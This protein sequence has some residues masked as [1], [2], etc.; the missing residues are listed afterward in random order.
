MENDPAINRSIETI[1]RIE[2][3]RLIAGLAR[4]TNGDLGQAEDLAQD[5]L[6]AA[7]ED[8]PATGI[9]EKPGAWLFSTARNRAIDGYR[10]QANLQQKYEQIGRQAEPLTP[11]VE[12][13]VEESL[14]DV[15]GDDILNL[16]FMTCHPLLSMESRVALTLRLIG[17]LTTDEIAR[18]FLVSSGTVGQR[19]SRAKRSLTEARVPFELPSRGDL[20]VRLS[21]VLEVVYLI[22]NEGYSATAGDDWIRPGLCEEAMRLGRIVVTLAPDEPEV[23]GLISLMEIQASRIPARTDRDGQPILLDNQDRSRWDRLLVK[24][25]LAA[26]EKAQELRA[27]LGP[28]TLQAAIAACHAR[29][30]SVEQTDWKRIAALYDALAQAT[31]SPVIELNRAV[32]VSRAFGP[33][34]ALLLTDRLQASGDL[35]GYH[36]LPAV[37]GDLLQKVGR[38]DEARVEFERAAMLAGNRADREIMIARAGECAP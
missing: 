35:S 7:I 16:I 5:A 31:P 13:E 11:T 19:I 28:Y 20:G 14:D 30:S 18:A 36:L 2:S 4:F 8:W 23:H 9:P 34:E 38:H 10:R 32:A 29:A 15:V 25:G 21:S 6:V 37:R 26:L 22:F 24:R 17:G 33:A 12:E 3:T 1:W 27:P